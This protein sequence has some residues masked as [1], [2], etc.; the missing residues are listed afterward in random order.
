MFESQ[1]LNELAHAM[2][3]QIERVA[4]AELAVDHQRL[5]LGDAEN[6]LRNAQAAAEEAIVR[7]YGGSKEMGSNQKE[8]DR[9]M[10]LALEQSNLPEVERARK[11]QDEAR[12][13][14]RELVEL[15]YVARLASERLRHQRYLVR[16]LLIETLR[17]RGVDPEAVL[18]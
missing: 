4:R 8:R 18:G 7:S 12:E 6:E 5:L 11:A 10:L 13:A 9:A 1:M 16:M 14:K 15:E 2:K 17:L 3:E